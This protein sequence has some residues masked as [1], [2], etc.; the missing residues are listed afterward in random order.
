MRHWDGW[1]LFNRILAGR[2][3]ARVRVGQPK[4]AQSANF[5]GRVQ[6]DLTK[7]CYVSFYGRNLAEKASARTN[8]PA[9]LSL[10]VYPPGYVSPNATGPDRFGTHRGD[11]WGG[12]VSRRRRSLEMISCEVAPC[13]FGTADGFRVK[14]DRQGMPVEAAGFSRPHA[15]LSVGKPRL[16][17]VGLQP[18]DLV[19][20]VLLWES[21]Q[22]DVQFEDVQSS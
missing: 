17:C 22:S 21:V 6:G 12:R 10:S 11:G 7:P 4:G 5:A 16:T 1:K 3:H 18:M 9:G 15:G 14:F 8:D 19:D 2:A 13:V 20:S